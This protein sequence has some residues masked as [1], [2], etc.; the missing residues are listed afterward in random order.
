MFGLAA[1]GRAELTTLA[2][3]KVAIVIPAMLLC[4]WLMRDSSILK[5]AYRLPNWAL[6]VVWSAMILLLIWAQESSSSFIYFQF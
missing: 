3:V 5:T 4:H 2:I 1:D 6:A